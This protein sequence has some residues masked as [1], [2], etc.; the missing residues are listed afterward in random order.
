MQ[1]YQ[2]GALVISNKN[3][4]MAIINSLVFGKAKNKIGNVVLFVIKGI[5]F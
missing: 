5:N 2:I 3:N 1:I 4:R